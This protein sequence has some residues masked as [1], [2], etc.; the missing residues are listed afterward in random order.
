MRVNISNITK[1][2]KIKKNEFN[3]KRLKIALFHPWIKSRGGAERVVLEIAKNLK[4]KVDIYTWVYDKNSTFEEFKKFKVKVIAPKIFYKASRFFIFRGAAFILPA[5]FSK[6]PLEKYDIFLISTGGFAELITFR[7]YKPG[8]TYAYVHTILRAAYRDDVKWNLKYRFKNPL[9]KLIYLIA[10][11][12]YRFLERLAWKRIDVAIFNSELSLERA[13][14]HNLLKGKKVYIVYP[15]INVRRFKKLKTKKGDY[16]L[17]VA[18]FGM[19]KRQDLLLEAWKKFVKKHPKYKLILVGG[20]ENKKYFERI[21]E[22]VKQIPNV[23]IKTDVS[24]K[25]LMELYANCLAGIFIPFMEDFG[26]VPFEFLACGKPLIAVDKGG[27]VNLIRKYGKKEI[28][29][30]HESKNLINNFANGLS[31]ILKFKKQGKKILIK[32]ISLYHF[33]KTLEKILK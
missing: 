33:I 29:L 14:K 22:M 15:P 13:K 20:I 11:Y 10:V 23:D 16:F 5:F 6:I 2:F 17:Y 7:N 9:V 28:I 12:V 31:K 18:R 21:R 24:D 26:I 27:Y 8:K 1:I 25:E 19:A 4:H 3:M 32:E 30:I